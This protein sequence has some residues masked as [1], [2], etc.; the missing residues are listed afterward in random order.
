MWNEEKQ[1]E[2]EDNSY[3]HGHRLSFISVRFEVCVCVCMQVRVYLAYGYAGT[4]NCVCTWRDQTRILDGFLYHALPHCVEMGFLTD[5]KALLF[6]Q[7]GWPARI[8]RLPFLPPS[9]ALGLQAH[10]AI[11]SFSYECWGFL[12]L[13]STVVYWVNFPGCGI[14]FFNWILMI[15]EFKSYVTCIPHPT[16]NLDILLLLKN[17]FKCTSR[18]LAV[19]DFMPRDRWLILRG[20]GIIL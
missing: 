17:W 5:P 2:E 6:N 18:F 12:M 8:I 15:N 19:V 20:Q 1:Q 11:P 13:T 3:N 16:H 14:L 7:M 9:P 10:T 4:G